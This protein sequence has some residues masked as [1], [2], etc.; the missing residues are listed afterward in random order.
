MELWPENWPVFEV[1]AQLRTQ[2][3]VAFGGPTGLDYAALYPLLD[4]AWRAD[5]EQWRM[6]FDDVREMEAAALEAMRQ[7]MQ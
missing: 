1:F 4:R 3:R 5:A 7:N 6:A 2:W